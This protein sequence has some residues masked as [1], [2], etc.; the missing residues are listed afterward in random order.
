MKKILECVPN[1][2]EGRNAAAIE[3]I[4]AEISAIEDTTLLDV[5]PGKATN[6]T[7]I[8]FAGEPEAVVEAAFRA[9]RK[10]TEVIDMS[11]HKGE[12]PRF[13]AADVCP[14][15]PVANVTMAET[16]EYARQLA[17]RVGEELAIPVYCYEEA[18]LRP[19][20]RDL[21]RVRSGEYEGLA[22]KLKDPQWVPDFGPAEFNPRAGAVAIGARGFL[23]AYN[24][25]LNT[26]SARR[27]NAVA[28][29]VRER[30]RVKRQ[31]NALTGAVVR[32]PDGA[33]V[34]TAGSLKNVK[35]LGWFI[36]E[37]GIAQIS[38]NL[39]DIEVTPLHVVFDEVCRKARDRGMRVTGS[40]IVGLVPL[41]AI[42]EAG[43][44]F[45]RKQQR[46][47]GIPESDIVNIAVKSLG[48]DDLA[49]FDA[50]SR[51]IEYAM[52][53]EE[54]GLVYKTV[55]EF[56]DETSSENPAP[57]GGSISAAVGA[58][59]AALAAMVANLS[60]HKR[61]WDERWEEFSDYAVE[62][63]GYVE[64]L[65]SLIDEDTRA[66]D[67]I[68]V[69]MRRPRHS[70]E[71]AEDRR[72]AIAAAT[73]QA[74]EVPMQVMRAAADSMR[75]IRTMAESGIPMSVSDSGVAALCART[76]VAGAYLNIKTNAVGLDD[77]AYARRLLKDAA[78]LDAKAEELEA[79]ILNIVD[80]KL[81]GEA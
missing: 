54:K 31:G 68:L 36:E 10:A 4:A 60:A 62:G 23:I 43:R 29:D 70:E 37:Y 74:M 40:E 30:G 46:S 14:L 69:A 3:Q 48:L 16:V 7:V 26:T 6:R 55:L 18:A 59:A 21:A 27:A 71:E 51:I 5:S 35:G 22:A 25:N 75:L 33:R 19:E 67:G 56:L 34:R 8:T 79:D 42:L 15:V 58:L 63:R 49:P 76:A 72:Q 39:T 77:K 53:D 11:R 81:R 64:R 78:E 20:R 12:H 47:L 32:A 38:L 41:G 2:S 80:R 9:I 73:K 24:V 1:V 17:E 28:F 45:L 61:G 66:Y 44:Y 13:G 57:G 50:G 65:S 52:A